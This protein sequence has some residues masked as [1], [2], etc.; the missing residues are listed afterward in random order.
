MSL[1][2]SAVYTSICPHLTLIFRRFFGGFLE[3]F[4]NT[5]EKQRS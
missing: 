4:Q 3:K 2:I 1:I 5:Y